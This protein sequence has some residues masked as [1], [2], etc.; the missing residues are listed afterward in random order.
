MNLRRWTMCAAAVCLAGGLARA[1]KDQ[2]PADSGVV[3]R[4]ETKLVVVDAVVTGKKGEYV[5]DLKQK[6]FKVYEDGKEQNVKSFA[7]EADPGSPNG[8]QNRYLVLFFDASSMNPGDQIQARQAA[9]KFVDANAGPNRLMAV[10]NFTGGL[11]IAQ[12]FTGNVD[13][14]KSAVSGVR[15]ASVNTSDA[16]SATS[17]QLNGA[18]NR[19]AASFAAQDLLLSI[20]N[21]AKALSAVPG[22]KTL[23]L[24]TAGFKMTSQAMS[25]VTAAVD[26][27]NKANV[28]I[29]PIDIRG[30]TTQLL[31]SHIGQRAR[32]RV[33]F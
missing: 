32:N 20:E 26:A 25:E 27:C 16:D 22:R 6:D 14:L 33:C 2:A 12:N 19:A 7:F 23:V 8:S 10:V 1:Q 30:L 29:Y 13:R 15:V 24:L 17:P 21:L 3:L 9:V 5:R 28:A 18:L 31:R 11:Q 4:T